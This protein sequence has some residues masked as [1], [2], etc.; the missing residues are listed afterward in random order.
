MDYP[1]EETDDHPKE[2]NPPESLAIFGVCNLW[3]RTSNREKMTKNCK[4][5]HKVQNIQT[6][7]YRKSYGSSPS[8]ALASLAP[9]QADSDCC[10]L[11][12]LQKNRIDHE[13][14][15]T[16]YKEKGDNSEEDLLDEYS[17]DYLV[18]AGPLHA[19]SY[20]GKFLKY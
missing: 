14:P 2:D 16:K 5:E 20:V 10:G 15:E 4:P 17:E 9:E 13:V 12:D 8:A 18:E 11:C 6:L 3:V 19:S 7:Y 1:T